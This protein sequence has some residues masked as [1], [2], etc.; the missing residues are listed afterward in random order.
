[1]ICTSEEYKK[2][3]INTSKRMTY[4]D[5]GTDPDYMNHFTAALFLPHTDLDLFPSVKSALRDQ[6]IIK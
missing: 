5:L 2:K 6:S 3:Q 1:M 4:I